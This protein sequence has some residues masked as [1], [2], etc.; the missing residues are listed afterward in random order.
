M[1]G[2]DPEIVILPGA[3]TGEDMAGLVRCLR[4]LFGGKRKF[5]AQHD[6]EQTGPEHGQNT[7]GDE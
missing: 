5:G 1:L 3:I 4:L 6:Q 2:I 7:A